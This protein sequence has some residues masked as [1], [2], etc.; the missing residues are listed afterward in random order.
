MSRSGFDAYF[1]ESELMAS[2]DKNKDGMISAT[3][4]TSKAELAF[5]VSLNDKKKILSL[6]NLDKNHDGYLTKD[7]FKKLLKDLTKEQVD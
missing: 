1:R 2:L 5:K 7:E 6:Q 4:L 3:E